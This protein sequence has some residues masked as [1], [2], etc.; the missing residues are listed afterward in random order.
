MIWILENPNHPLVK[1]V[2]KGWNLG[3]DVVEEDAEDH[4]SIS[5]TPCELPS[6]LAGC[7]P[8]K[9]EEGQVQVKL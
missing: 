7:A 1:R 5:A 8:S 4:E 2:I 9:G 3:T 6:L